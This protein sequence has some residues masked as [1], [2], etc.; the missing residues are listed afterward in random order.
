MSQIQA[1]TNIQNVS[2]K[3]LPDVAR[4]VELFAQDVVRVVNGQLDFATNFSAKTIVVT[5]SNPNVDVIAGHGLG[6]VPTGY[7][8]AGLSTAMI[9][10]TGSTPWSKSTITLRSNAAG[11]ASVLVY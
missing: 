5:F 8:I 6:R 2:E 10:Y 3:G 9:V 1:A 7:I 11:T 4:F